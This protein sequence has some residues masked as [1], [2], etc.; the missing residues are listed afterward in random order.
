MLDTTPK[1]RSYLQQRIS[2]N[3]RKSDRNLRQSEV[4]RI[5]AW[6]IRANLGFDAWR[7]DTPA[8][9][10]YRYLPRP[11]RSVSIKA[12]QNWLSCHIQNLITPQT[13]HSCRVGV[14]RAGLISWL[15]GRL[16]N[17]SIK[18]TLVVSRGTDRIIIT[19]QCNISIAT[20]YAI[21]QARKPDRS[22]GCL[23]GENPRGCS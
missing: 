17:H 11:P 5:M 10:A 3:R 12:S 6:C 4:I 2:K 22:G 16:T 15:S 14:Y 23:E 18:R 8:K 1:T 7:Q 9:P 21:C 19:S 20:R 13:L